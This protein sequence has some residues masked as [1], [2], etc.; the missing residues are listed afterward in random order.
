MIKVTRMRSWNINADNL[1]EAVNFY[2]KALG[3]NIDREHTVAGVK[4]ARLSLGDSTIGLFDSSEGPRPG[5]PHHTFEIQGAGPSE[6]L[7]RE[8]ESKGIPVDH[9]RQHGDGPG[10]SVY[11]SDPCGN[12]IELSYD[13]A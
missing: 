11:I 8:L 13:P 3:A 4:V 2:Q 5:V 12:D 1:D 6:D 10:Y 9:T 7:V